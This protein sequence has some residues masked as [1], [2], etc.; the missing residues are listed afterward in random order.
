MIRNQYE[1]INSLKAIMS[2]LL[3]ENGK[4][5]KASSS[6]NKGKKKKARLL[7]G[8][9]IA[10]ITLVQALNLNQRRNLVI[11]MIAQAR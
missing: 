7:P 1:T 10:M 8:T 3:E 6:S 9:L 4:Q 11:K 5:S 2:I